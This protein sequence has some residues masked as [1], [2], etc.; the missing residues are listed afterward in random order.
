MQHHEI[1]Q[2]VSPAL[3]RPKKK[4]ETN[5][6]QKQ[7]H[8][9]MTHGL[10]IPQKGIWNDA[11]FFHPKLLLLL[12]NVSNEEALIPIVLKIYIWRLVRSKVELSIYHHASYLA[13]S[14]IPRFSS[15][16]LILP[17]TFHLFFPA[18]CLSEY[19]W[20]VAILFLP[21]HW[22]SSFPLDSIGH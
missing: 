3:K 22:Q 13:C 18:H 11:S 21:L 8:T 6:K 16:P 10:I 4:K 5:K 15:L 17:P 1:L 12:F 20:H 19:T 7:H 2:S 14:R 9:A